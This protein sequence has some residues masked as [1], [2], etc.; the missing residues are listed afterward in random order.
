LLIP[1]Q[2]G[3]LPALVV[4]LSNVG[5]GL[6]SILLVGREWVMTKRSKAGR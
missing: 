1:L 6:L 4:Y 3:K 2:V 5:G